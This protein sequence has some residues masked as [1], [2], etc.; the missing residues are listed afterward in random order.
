MCRG[1]RLA[2]LNAQCGIG[3]VVA[4]VAVD[5]AELAAKFG[6]SFW[7]DASAEFGHAV[8]GAL[9]QLLDRPAGLGDA[10]HGN[11]QRAM[12]HHALQRGKDFLVGEIAGCAKENEGIGML[13]HGL[14]LAGE[15]N[16]MPRNPIW[17]ISKYRQQVYP[18]SC[19]R[20]KSSHRSL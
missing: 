3:R 8:A 6:K 19:E 5:I 1:L 15:E 11:I 10:D 9:A 14:L 12:F 16:E 13:Q 4:I 20:G 2:Q 7:V 17:N 18:Q